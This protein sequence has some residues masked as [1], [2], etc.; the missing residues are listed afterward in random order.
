MWYQPGQVS[1]IP[2][3]LSP[4]LNSELVLFW[5]QEMIPHFQP[6]K[7]GCFKKHL[8]PFKFHEF[9][10]LLVGRHSSG[11]LFQDTNMVP[12]TLRFEIQCMIWKSQCWL[13]RF[14]KRNNGTTEPR[15]VHRLHPRAPPCGCSLQHGSN[16]W[17]APGHGLRDR[18]PFEKSVDGY[19]VLYV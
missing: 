15:Q 1:I 18:K 8:K 17:P 5:C 4:T 16:T 2:T 9:H 11:V 10:Y 13:F 7:L 12:L 14:M 3:H 19:I 6:P